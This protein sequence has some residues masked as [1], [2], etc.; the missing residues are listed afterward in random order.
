VGGIPVPVAATPL[1]AF[2]YLAEV[3]APLT[4]GG[5]FRVPDVAHFELP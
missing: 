4:W 5:N 1:A 3:L 2:E